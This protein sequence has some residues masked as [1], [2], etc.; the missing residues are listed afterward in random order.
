[1]KKKVPPRETAILIKEVPIQIKNNFKA[2]CAKR[3]ITLRQALIDLMQEAL[4]KEAQ[5]EVHRN[6]ARA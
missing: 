4:R 5:N 6:T 3:G 2:Q 1:M